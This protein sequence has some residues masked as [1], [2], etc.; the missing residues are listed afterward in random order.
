MNFAE[1]LAAIMHD[2]VREQGYGVGNP[3]P[4]PLYRF[5][6]AVQVKAG[7][8]RDRERPAQEKDVDA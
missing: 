3:L 4:D 6:D 1:R 2:V 5:I 8:V 7:R